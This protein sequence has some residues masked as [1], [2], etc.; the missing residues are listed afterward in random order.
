ME[1][2]GRED[3]ERYVYLLEILTKRSC[4]PMVYLYNLFSSLPRRLMFFEQA[5]EHAER[6]FKANPKDALV[7]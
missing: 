1:T 2:L 7:R 5:R 3:I 4:V 6:E